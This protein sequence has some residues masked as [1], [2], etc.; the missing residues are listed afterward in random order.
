MV[1]KYERWQAGNLRD[2]LRMQERHENRHL[3]L[4][5]RRKYV[6]PEKILPLVQNRAVTYVE[7]EELR[8]FDNT[9]VS[10]L[11]ELRQ[12]G[13]PLVVNVTEKVDDEDIFT[14]DRVRHMLSCLD[15]VDYVVIPTNP[16]EQFSV[17]DESIAAAGNCFFFTRDIYAKS[18]E[19]VN[20]HRSLFRDPAYDIHL[21]NH[22]L[23]NASNVE[24]AVKYYQSQEL[25]VTV[26]TGVLDLLHPGHIDFL[27]SASMQGQILI[28]LTNSD[29]SA[30]MQDKNL[31]LGDRP[32]YPLR[33]RVPTMA[34]LEF[35][36]HIVPFDSKAALPILEKL[37]G[38]V[39]VKTTKD[40]DSAT[41]QQEIATVEQNGGRAEILPTIEN[42]FTKETMSSTL[43]IN[44]TRMLTTED[45]L[46][47]AE[48]AL[49][50]EEIR[51]IFGDAI[52]LIKAWDDN[53]PHLLRWSR[54]LKRRYRT[55]LEDAKN[56]ERW[57]LE[58]I[59]IGT[60]KLLATTA[61]LQPYHSYVIPYLI[62]KMLNLDI[63]MIPI[64]YNSGIKQ[65]IINAALLSDGTIGFFDTNI[66]AAYEPFPFE[67]TFWRA[68]PHQANFIPNEGVNTFAS[69]IYM[70]PPERHRLGIAAKILLD[71][72]KAGHNNHFEKEIAGIISKIW[73]TYMFPSLP[74]NNL[75]ESK[76]P[77]KIEFQFHIPGVVGHGGEA[78]L[79]TAGGFPENSRSGLQGALIKGVDVIEL[80]VV[81]CRDGWIVSHDTLLD[82]ATEL[83]E[84]KTT[85][86]FTQDQLKRI[87]LR[88]ADG[89]I[90]DETLMSL[91]EALGMI[92]EHR[93]SNYGQV[94]AKIDIK[95]S[96]E[97]NEHILVEQVLSSGIALNQVLIT[98][99]IPQ[100]SERIYRIAPELNFELNPVEPFLFFYGFDIQDEN[101]VP[102]VLLEFFRSSAAAYNGRTVSIPHFCM[103]RWG[104]KVYQRI[105]QGTHQLGFESQV[106]VIGN[107]RD[108]LIASMLGVTYVL[109]HKPEIITQA[110]EV[111]EKAQPVSVELK[112][113][114]NKALEE[115]YGI[116]P[117]S[118]LELNPNELIQYMLNSYRQRMSVDLTEYLLYLQNVLSK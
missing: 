101:I 107:I 95:Y 69:R 7:I 103:H 16:Q 66:P 88:L 46:E 99:S 116:D 39:Y 50:P 117:N 56:I 9:L 35:V 58:E 45:I 43:R 51:N 100:A 36:D 77:R 81:P 79:Q 28:I 14:Q 8:F 72:Q 65:R 5:E 42:P 38:I 97:E 111:K 41:V 21:S 67:G 1:Y 24:E 18:V 110:L 2:P 98:S 53:S 11:T 74:G 29:E 76:E 109:M 102:E 30:S 22:K 70:H 90:S 108:Y 12:K 86:D 82:V 20:R 15:M 54:D 60:H 26:V 93:K 55:S 23:M 17:K 37:P 10:L 87:R 52:K 96:L 115:L 114:A 33:D 57:V 118:N 59:C 62:G 73:P 44:K 75:S 63:R 32:I 85:L 91:P 40:L 6:T 84:G 113:F 94:V 61:D 71:L 3:H 27:E 47:I 34:A 78:V 104:D 106:W 92:A 49:Y 31:S 64:I 25:Q 13:K 105:I 80:D 112:I 4:H 89:S 48:I 83:S 68:F 19:L